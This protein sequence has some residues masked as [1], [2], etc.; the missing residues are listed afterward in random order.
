[1]YFYFYYSGCFATSFKTR[2][3]VQDFTTYV[4]MY[5]Y[6]CTVCSANIIDTTMHVIRAR[7][8]ADVCLALQ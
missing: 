8:Y 2:N 4:C 5:V 3:F 7:I 6:G 1:M